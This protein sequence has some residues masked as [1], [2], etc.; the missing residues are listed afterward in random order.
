M[1]GFNKTF[2]IAL[3]LLLVGTTAY[4]QILPISLELRGGSNIA[5]MDIEG[6]E[7]STRAGLNAGLAAQ[8]SI[9]LTSFYLESGLMFSAKGTDYNN[10]T[11]AA[12]Y[13]Q[14]P[15]LVG[16]KIGLLPAL[17]LKLFAGPY[18]AHG[19]AGNTTVSGS[20][21]KTFSDTGLKR[22]DSGI[23]LGGGL[24]FL[25]FSFQAG[26]EYGWT[27]ISQAGPKVQNRNTFLTFGYKF[28]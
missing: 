1:R 28:F 14:V 5:K 7:T 11:I 8:F 20:R 6:Q 25:M 21:T 2:A 4:S 22:F 27:D 10:T 3:V 15:V 18:F 13:L 17:R 9:P 19:I 23:T 16:Y 26:Y 24:E 12:H